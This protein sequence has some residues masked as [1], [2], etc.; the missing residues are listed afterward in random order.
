MFGQKNTIALVCTPHLTI[1][2][3]YYIE[4]IL[5]FSVRFFFHN[6]CTKTRT[7]SKVG[8]CP[9]AWPGQARGQAQDQAS[10]TRPCHAMFPQNK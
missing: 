9:L 5:I 8:V 3:R 10:L 6:F 4:T 7:F 2:G 1:F